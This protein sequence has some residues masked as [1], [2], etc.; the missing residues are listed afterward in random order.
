[1]NSYTQNDPRRFSILSNSLGFGQ[2]FTMAILPKPRTPASKSSK[3]WGERKRT[4]RAWGEK[5]KARGEGGLR[6]E[7]ERSAYVFSPF[8]RFLTFSSLTEREK[9]FANTA[10]E[11]YLTSTSSG[12]SLLLFANIVRSQTVE[13]PLL[14]KRSKLILHKALLSVSSGNCTPID[15]QM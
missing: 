4:S 12:Q 3:A 14:F 11:T 8:P 9:K 10:V 2:D 15:I 6:R 7:K 5:N 13:I 1:M